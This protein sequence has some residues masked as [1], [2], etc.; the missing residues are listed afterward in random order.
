VGA[1]QP[2]TSVLAP[3]LAV[4]LVGFGVQRASATQPAA[5]AVPGPQPIRARETLRQALE[6]RSVVITSE[7]MGGRPRTSSTTAA[8]RRST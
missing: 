2:V 8:S 5:R 3:A 1:E 6:P 4:V 7:D